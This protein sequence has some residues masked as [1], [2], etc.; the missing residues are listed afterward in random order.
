MNNNDN[1]V[2]KINDVDSDHSVDNEIIIYQ[3]NSTFSLDVRVDK[4]TVWLTQ[5]QIA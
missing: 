5:S 3:P 4:E 1:S 2:L